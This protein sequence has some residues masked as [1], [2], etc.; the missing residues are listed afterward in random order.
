MLEADIKDNEEEFDKLTREIA[1]YEEVRV[2]LQEMAEA[3]RKQVAAGLENIVTLCLQSVFGPE[4]SFEI[5]IDTSR[6]N[7][8][9]EFYVV[10]TEGETAVRQTLEDSY[11]GGVVDTAAIGLRYGML[12]V[13]N[14]EPIGPIILDE[15]AKM[16]SGDRIRSIGSLIR[17]LNR[18]FKKQS[19]MVTHHEPLMDMV[20]N[21]I[22]FEKVDGVTIAS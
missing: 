3:T 21:A 4:M 11:G 19:I 2:F 17:E 13:L 8:V 22:Y 6:N 1:L 10:N 12:K 9:I 16:V 7:T 15:P 20:D 5:D 18:L 14:P